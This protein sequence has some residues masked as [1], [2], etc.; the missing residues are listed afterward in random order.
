M[1]RRRSFGLSATAALA[2]AAQPLAAAP[3]N[4]PRPAPPAPTANEEDPMA[5]LG[6]MFTA[7]PLT[8]DQQARL[9]Q[10]QRIVALLIPDG[11]LGEMMG[12]TFDQMLGPI[13]SQSEAP[14][15]ATIAKGTGFAASDLDLTDAQTAELAALFDPAYAERH[16]REMALV[17]E[18]MRSITTAIEPTMRKAMAELYAIHFT[19][20]EL[21]DIET[22]FKTPSG[23]A[24]ARKSF[25]MSSDPRIMAATM[26]AMP[27]LMQGFEAMG[28]KAD[29]ATA[30]LGKPRSFA[31]LSLAEKAKV[32]R[33]TGYSVK[34]IEEQLA[35]RETDD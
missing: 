13:L 34:E 27:E 8:A 16:K 26:E 28:K 29:A 5:M 24:Y 2:L 15:A 14:G 3:P 17:P 33:L 9:P 18:M 35:A 21:A 22:F 20:A 12:K 4:S 30:D 31:D 32:A 23:T 1:I 7:E 11:T 6:K 25:T 19:P 10:A